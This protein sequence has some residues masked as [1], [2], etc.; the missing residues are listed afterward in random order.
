M[1]L[2]RF[3]L[4]AGLLAALAA[5]SVVSAQAGGPSPDELFQKLDKNADG[6]L[7]ADEISEDQKRFFDRTVRVGDKDN[8]G[9]LTKDEFV[10]ANK[11]QENPGVPLNPQGDGRPGDRMAELR[12]RFEM[13]DRNK[14]GK[15]TKDE[16]PEQLRDRMAQLFERA[17]KDSVTIEEF[18]RFS[19]GPPGG[20]GGRP[21]P[22]QLF[23]RFD[24]NKDGKITKDE[25][26]EPMRERFAQAFERIGKTELTRDDF[27]SAS[28]MAF[29]PNAPDGRPM[30]GPMGGRPPVFL[31]LAD[32]D[33]DGKISKDELAKL[34]DKFGELDR[35]NDGTLDLSE[36]MGGPPPGIGRPEMQRPDGTPNTRPVAGGPGSNPFFARMDANGDGKISKDEA[37]DRLKENFDRM[38]RNSDGF[39][40]QEEMQSAFERGGQRPGQPGQ[41]S[42]P[43]RPRRP[44]SE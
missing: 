3:T 36:L 10:Q 39:L 26:P 5:P 7:N 24:A 33:G 20:Q 2:H 41:P 14:D 6:K 8:D 15:I 25:L 9:V 17:G 30:D 22:G 18:G 35:N 37:P 32:A 21:D 43:G 34:A 40:T 42:Q 28:R 31:R 44:Q 1:R 38:D 13:M 19:G 23:D 16:I 4:A 29:G 12:Q 11:P 27:A